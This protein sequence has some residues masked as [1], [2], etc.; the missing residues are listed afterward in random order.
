[1]R[2]WWIYFLVVSSSFL[3]LYYPF[4]L[5]PIILLQK[6]PAPN[7]SSFR[8]LYVGLPTSYNFVSVQLPPLNVPTKHEI[9]A[10][11]SIQSD[12][13]SADNLPT[14]LPIATPESYQP[15]DARKLVSI[16]HWVGKI[17]MSNK[18]NNIE[19]LEIRF[20]ICLTVM[21]LFDPF[22]VNFMF[23]LTMT[24]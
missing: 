6:F 16:T 17:I 13:L 18:L 3:H 10:Y 5:K 22:D 14:A 20:T 1:M 24:V 8:S 9:C 19:I 2:Y 21:L 11:S 7:S 23:D 4:C 15:L 12:T